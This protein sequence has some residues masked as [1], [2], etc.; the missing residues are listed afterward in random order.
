[1]TRS[2]VPAAPL[3]GQRPRPASPSP[4]RRPAIPGR[5]HRA[6]ANLRGA[7]GRVLRQR[8]V[9][10]PPSPP[11]VHAGRSLMTLVSIASATAAATTTT[12]TTTRRKRN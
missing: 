2:D 3:A 11:R 1:M 7:A 4:W 10:R 8:A 12:T 6:V 9:R 5:R